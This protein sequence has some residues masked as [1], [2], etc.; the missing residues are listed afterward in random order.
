MKPG[1]GRILFLDKNHPESGLAPVIRTIE[2]N[3]PRNVA[4][5]KIYLA[6]EES[7]CANLKG[8]PYSQAFMAQVLTNAALRTSHP[9]LDNSDLAN[10]FAVCIMFLGLN[11]GTI[12]DRSFL[13]NNVLD[14]L[15]R[16]PIVNESPVR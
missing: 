3:L 5:L 7:K 8:Y 4:H 9:T 10:A 12:F 13:A 1:D 6:P 11:R 15:M 2:E 16:L 14:D